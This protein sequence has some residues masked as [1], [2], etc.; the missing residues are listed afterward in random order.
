[1]LKMKIT[2]EHENL[3]AET[4]DVTI[5]RRILDLIAPDIPVMVA[6]NEKQKECTK[7]TDADITELWGDTSKLVYFNYDTGEWNCSK[8]N[9][10]E[11]EDQ[12]IDTQRARECKEI[13][14]K[15]HPEYEL[16]AMAVMTI[17]EKD[18]PGGQRDIDKP[19][20]NRKG[21]CVVGNVIFRNRTIGKLLTRS[22]WFG[23]R[24]HGA[25]DYAARYGARRFPF[26]A[27]WDSDFRVALLA[28]VFGETSEA[29]N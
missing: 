19:K 26:F 27:A 13:V 8:Y 20:Y 16:V 2:I 21:S 24:D 23:V 25:P 15:E 29:H 28:G 5:A 9:G 18:Y 4:H 12:D 22:A 6:E 11:I 3:Q 10:Y 1:M 14:D 7:L 17:S